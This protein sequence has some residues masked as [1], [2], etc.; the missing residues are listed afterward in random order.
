MDVERFVATLRS[1]VEEAKLLGQYKVFISVSEAENL[2][3][4]L[5]KVLDVTIRKGEEGQS[6]V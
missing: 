1:D 4:I 6:D 3:L 5:D 2:L